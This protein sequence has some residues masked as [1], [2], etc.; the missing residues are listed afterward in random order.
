[1]EDEGAALTVMAR[2]RQPVDAFFDGVLVMDK[3]EAI[4]KI[5]W[6]SCRRSSACFS[7]WRISRKS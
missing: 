7:R 2:M 3:D 6:P 5:A 4:R 1:V